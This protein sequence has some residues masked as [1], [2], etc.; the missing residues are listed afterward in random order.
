MSMDINV[1]A[2]IVI[3][4]VVLGSV[5]FGYWMGRNSIGR[6]MSETPK[7]FDPGKPGVEYDP[8]E[9]ALKG[10]PMSRIPTIEGE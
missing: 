2:C 10:E 5:W 8:Y 4:I 7:Q 9:E 6:P 3:V 1:L